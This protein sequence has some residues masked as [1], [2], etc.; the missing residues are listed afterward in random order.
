MTPESAPAYSP[1]TELNAAELAAEEAAQR[2]VDA[3]AAGDRPGASAWLV[4]AQQEIATA[5]TLA[6]LALLGKENDR[7]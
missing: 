1:T 7:A 5:N 3:L 6:D 4:I 2:A